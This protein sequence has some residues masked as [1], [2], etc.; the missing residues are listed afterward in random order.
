[1][2]RQLQPLAEV[3]AKAQE[4]E[5][6]K[7]KAKAKTKEKAKARESLKT[8]QE[9]VVVQV[10]GLTLPATSRTSAPVDA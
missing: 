5:K 8:V 1:M 3:M 7:E 10:A 9:Q 2:I 6:V 4:E